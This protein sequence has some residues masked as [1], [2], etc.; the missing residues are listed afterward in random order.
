ML[1]IPPL[2]NAGGDV[3][4]WQHWPAEKQQLATALLAKYGLQLILSEADEPIPGSFWGDDEAGLVASCLYVRPD[5]PVHSLLHESC[6]YIC[7]TPA[8]RGALHTNAG[9]TV[10]EECAVCYLQLLLADSLGIAR[11]LLFHD[12][13][14][15]G[16]SFRLG[17]AEQWFLRDA[18]DA[19]AWLQQHQ[20]VDGNSLPTG[21]LRQ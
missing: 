20:L 12:M 21:Q 17:S 11:Q 19:L 7:M 16:Y 1:A 6:H 3:L 15:W 14:S 4:R 10:L 18:D 9:G 8:R 13:D 5:T 2:T